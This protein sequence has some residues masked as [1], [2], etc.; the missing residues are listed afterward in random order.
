VDSAVIHI[1]SHPKPIADRAQIDNVLWL[2][3]IAFAGKRKMLRNT[4]GSI[5]GGAEALAQVKID[6]TRRPENL[7][8]DEWLALARVVPTPH[9]TEKE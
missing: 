6:P 4:L 1:V 5:E 7:K 8:V 2:L 9:G 3:K